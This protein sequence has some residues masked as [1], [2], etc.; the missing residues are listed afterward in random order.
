MAMTA[1]FVLL[2]VSASASIICAIWL[3]LEMTDD[4]LVDVS[5]DPARGYVATH[6]RL[7]APV[8]ALS[9]TVLR[10]R[11][12]AQLGGDVRLKLDRLARE[13]RDE[14]RRGGAARATDTTPV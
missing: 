2:I 4:L 7:A 13:Q 12:G 11:L 6:P 8:M 10:A 14:R 1:P 3:V 9:L 5:F